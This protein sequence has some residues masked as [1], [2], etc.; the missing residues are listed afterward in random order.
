VARGDDGE[1]LWLVTLFAVVGDDQVIASVA[2]DQVVGAPYDDSG[3][4]RSDRVQIL[5]CLAIR[6]SPIVHLVAPESAAYP[7]HQLVVID[8]LVGMQPYVPIQA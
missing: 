4:R 8:I 2:L 7:T 3:A 1:V 5:G 6:G